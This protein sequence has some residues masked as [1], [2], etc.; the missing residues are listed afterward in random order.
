MKRAVRKILESEKILILSHRRPDGDS[1][2]SQ[3]GL[4]TALKLLKKRVICINEDEVPEVFGFLKSKKLIKTKIKIPSDIDLIICLDISGFD[5]LGERLS[6]AIA[7]NKTYKINIDHHTSN[8]RFCDLN[9][10]EEEASSTSEMIYNL[11]KML[12]VKPDN[13]IAEALL[14]GIITDTGGFRFSNTASKTLTITAD[15]IESGADLSKLSV[16]IY[17]SRPF[18]KVR[19][20]SRMIER[21]KVIGDKAFSYLK[22]NDFSE[23]DAKMEYTEGLVNEMLN[24]KGI[25]FSVLLTEERKDL[26]RISFRSKTAKYNADQFAEKFGG[27]GH[28]YAAGGRYNG[29]IKDA[30]KNLEKEIR[31]L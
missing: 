20:S 25:N 1:I 18:A 8:E 9:I 30:L 5:R 6:G 28:K 21:M 16:E 13:T 2:G 24:I 14:T 19:L 4:A 26:A 23:L 15:L 11:I 31:K 17:M 10:V 7:N 12:K 29:S 22:L 3:L 27:G